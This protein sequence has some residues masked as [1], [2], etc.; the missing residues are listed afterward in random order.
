MHNIDATNIVAFFKEVAT[1]NRRMDGKIRQQKI[2]Q[3][4]LLNLLSSFMKKSK[5]RVG[6][7]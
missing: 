4:G 1:M 6:N 2:E 7:T 3:R 5:D